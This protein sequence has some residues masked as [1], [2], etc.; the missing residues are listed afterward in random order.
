MESQREG[1][2]GKLGKGYKRGEKKRILLVDFA[3]GKSNNHQKQP[4]K[5]T[6]STE[7]RK[8]ESGAHVY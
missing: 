1:G 3:K 4:K 6:K 8:R 5:T 7:K 2:K